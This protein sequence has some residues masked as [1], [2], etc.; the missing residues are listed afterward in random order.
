MPAAPA[1]EMIRSEGLCR[2]FGATRAVDGLDLSISAGSCFGL[3]GA[4]G[5]GKSTTIQLLGTL[6]R[7][8]SGTAVVAGHRVDR[9][10]VKV[11]A[12]LGLVFQDAALDRSLTVMENLRFAGALSGLAGATVATRSSELLTLFEIADKRDSLVAKLSGGQRR[13]VD[14]A[15]ALLHRPSV[16][17]LDEPTSGLDPL[18]RRTL[19]RFLRRLCSEQGTTLLVATHLLDEAG[20]CDEVLF[21]AR[22]R[23][24]GHGR[25]REL[26]ARTGAFIL[27][28]TGDEAATTAFA[29]LGNG[30]RDGAT[31]SVRITDPGFTL[32]QLDA[33]ALARLSAVTLRSPRLEDVYLDLHH[34]EAKR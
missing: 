10:P 24:L 4:N 33:Q 12:A 11:R 19:W 29:G 25:P 15:R 7:P 27:E 26:I 1:A 31:L 8:S 21:M 34:Q 32:A 13:M 9:E 3:L 20:E 18:N 30:R 28:V 2:I 6:L 22:G 5:S 16:L 14:I 17:L 23:A